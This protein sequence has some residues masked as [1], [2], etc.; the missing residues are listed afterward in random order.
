MWLN[1]RNNNKE[2]LKQTIRALGYGPFWTNTAAGLQVATQLLQQV[3]H[4]HSSI[5]LVILIQF[6][7]SS[8]DTIIRNKL[9]NCKRSL[10]FKLGINFHKTF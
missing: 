7:L 6:F 3:I 1:S 10:I 5:D 8:I 2:L 4:K 9:K